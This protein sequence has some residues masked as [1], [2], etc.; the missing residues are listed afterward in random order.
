MREAP[1]AFV[2]G[3]F[4]FT[5]INLIYRSSWRPTAVESNFWFTNRG[6]WVGWI[7]RATQDC[8]DLA[9]HLTHTFLWQ[10]A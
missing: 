4:S 10:S 2:L 9:C 6:V 1:E 3:R 7:L 8:T 5:K